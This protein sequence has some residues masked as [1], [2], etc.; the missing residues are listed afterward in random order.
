M[1]PENKG[2][3]MAILAATFAHKKSP[4]WAAGLR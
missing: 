3:N 4:I 2:D 1:L